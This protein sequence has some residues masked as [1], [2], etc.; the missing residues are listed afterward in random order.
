[1][2]KFRSLAPSLLATIHSCLFEIVFWTSALS[3]I[4]MHIQCAFSS[5]PR[6]HDL[7]SLLFVGNI[8]CR[9]AVVLVKYFSKFSSLWKEISNAPT[10]QRKQLWDVAFS[11]IWTTL[12]L[13]VCT[14]YCWFT[15][16]R[17]KNR[18]QCKAKIQSRVCKPICPHW[19]T[20]LQSKRMYDDY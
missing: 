1:M 8:Y 14:C 17:F 11:A 4:D 18:P 16:E 9:Q 2:P 5:L 13:R 15:S 3:I 6:Y 12:W 19:S 7:P 10:R 20:A